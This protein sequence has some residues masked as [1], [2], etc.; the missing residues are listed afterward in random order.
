MEI[1]EMILKILLTIIRI[2]FTVWYLLIGSVFWLGE[3]L[4]KLN[5]NTF[6]FLLSLEFASLTKIYHF[7]Q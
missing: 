5:L 3:K 4:S 7:K 2:P 1:N 6:Y